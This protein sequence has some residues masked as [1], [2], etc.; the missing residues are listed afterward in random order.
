MMNISCNLIVAFLFSTLESLSY[1]VININLRINFGIGVK[2]F[3]L[4]ILVTF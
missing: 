1:K 3:K 2:N 4:Y